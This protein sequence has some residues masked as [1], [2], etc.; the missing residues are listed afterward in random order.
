MSSSNEPDVLPEVPPPRE[1]EAPPATGAP[2]RAWRPALV[3]DG[4]RRTPSDWLELA[5]FASIL[6]LALATPTKTAD[7]R[8]N[9]PGMAWLDRTTGGGLCFFKRF[10]GI[11]CGGCGLTRAYVQLAHLHPIEA[12]KLNPL[13]PAVFAWSTWHLLTVLSRLFLR[14]RLLHGLPERWV[15]RGYVAT[16]LGFFL[17]GTYRLIEGLLRT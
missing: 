9:A 7:G 5:L 15:W 1:E 14:K 2:G 8:P 3:P 13:A 11:E 6:I 16:F 10:S 12:V 4:R 17:L